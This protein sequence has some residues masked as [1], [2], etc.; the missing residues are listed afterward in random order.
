MSVRYSPRIVTDGLILCVDAAN[1]KSYIGSGSVVNDLSG[2]NNNL[3]LTG[4]TYQTSPNAF[5]YDAAAER[6]ISDSD[7]FFTTPTS[8][9]MSA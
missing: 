1:P 8:M 6:I 5:V 9:S 3:T 2:N 4:P 7:T